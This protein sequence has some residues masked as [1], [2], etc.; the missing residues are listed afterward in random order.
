M[1]TRIDGSDDVGYDQ[2][3]AL[4]E[5]LRLHGPVKACNDLRAEIAGRWPQRQAGQD[6]AEW[7]RRTHTEIEERALRNALAR[8]AE[9]RQARADLVA[10]ER[11][12][13]ATGIARATAE[14]AQLRDASHARDRGRSERRAGRHAVALVYAARASELSPDLYST[15]FL[16]SSQRHARQPDAALSS[17]RSLW[18]HEEERYRVAT[19]AAAVLADQGKITAAWDLLEPWLTRQEDAY[20]LQLAGRLRRLLGDL[21]SAEQYLRR[22]LGR[23]GDDA[24]TRRVQHELGELARQAKEAGDQST[25]TAAGALCT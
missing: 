12:D 21:A 18:R 5:H 20:H 9:R 22:A 8:E 23:A 25:A 6:A 19:G 17:Y 1:G 13:D 7:I 14:A 10:A 3:L 24:D 4:L 16:A 15:L 11:R 2:A